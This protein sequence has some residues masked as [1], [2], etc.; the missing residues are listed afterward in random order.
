MQSCVVFCF[1]SKRLLGGFNESADGFMWLNQTSDFQEVSL[2]GKSKGN[3]R[4]SRFSLSSTRNLNFDVFFWIFFFFPVKFWFWTGEYKCS[5]ICLKV[6]ICGLFTKIRDLGW[7]QNLTEPLIPK[8]EFPRYQRD[9]QCRDCMR[10][11]VYYLCWQAAVCL[12]IYLFHFYKK[13]M[14]V[15]LLLFLLLWLLVEESLNSVRSK[16]L[17]LRTCV[18]K[19]PNGTFLFV[20]LFFFS[21]YTQ[22]IKINFFG[23]SFCKQLR[24]HHY[25]CRNWMY[26]KRRSVAA[27]SLR[28]VYTLL[29]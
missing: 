9:N 15:F 11:R 1:F 8:L 16:N 10:L 23:F 18:K 7:R 28:S 6:W 22:L 29:S 24:L 17:V 26:L 25:F 12:L 21:N 13:Y 2:V 3:T 4:S 20:C 14:T 5:Q 19:A 27:H